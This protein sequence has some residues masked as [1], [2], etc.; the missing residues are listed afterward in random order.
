MSKPVFENIFTLSGRR[1]RKSYFLFGLALT[2]M[3]GVLMMILLG[4]ALGIESPR[5]QPGGMRTAMM[6][7]MTVG[8]LVLA[9]ILAVP[10]LISGLIVGAQRCRDFGWTGWAVLLI[11]IPY[12]GS[13]FALAILLMPGTAGPNRYGADPL[14]DTGASALS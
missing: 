5:A 12:I 13:L 8:A 7:G 3:L 6:T 10:A 1:N 9:G 11:L 2:A 4:L 14:A